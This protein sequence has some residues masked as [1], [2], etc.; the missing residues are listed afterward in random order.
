MVT[1]AFV[2]T[3]LPGSFGISG[4]GAMWSSIDG[5]SVYFESNATGNIYKATGLS[6]TP[7]FSQVGHLGA[8]PN[9]DG[10]SCTQAP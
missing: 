2:T 6:G 5:Q 1:H 7:G 8:A 3:T 4:H 10:A 9:M